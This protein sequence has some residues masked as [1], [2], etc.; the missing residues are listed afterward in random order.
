MNLPPPDKPSIAVLPFKNMSGDK[1]QEY[2]SDGL[3]ED[4]ITDLSR[5]SGLFVIAPN[6]VFFYKNNP[7]KIGKIGQDLGGQLCS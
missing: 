5:V 6:S 4:L 1:E 2:F 7:V 3:T